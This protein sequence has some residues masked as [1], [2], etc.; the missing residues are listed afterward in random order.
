MS[1]V[2]EIFRLLTMGDVTPTPDT[3]VTRGTGV[4]VADG[5]VVVALDDSGTR[6]LLIPYRMRTKGATE[7]ALTFKSRNLGNPARPH[8]DLSCTRPELEGVFTAFCEHLL[9]TVEVGSDALVALRRA[10]DD[11]K[12]LLRA[13]SGM[14]DEVAIGLI[15][16]LTILERLAAVDP[17]AAWD[18]WTGHLKQVHDFTAVSSELEVKATTVLDGG[19]VLIHGLDQLDP[20]DRPLYLVVYRLAPD[21]GAPTLDE[22]MDTLVSMGIPRHDLLGVVTPLGH[23]YGSGQPADEH[24]Y[25]VRTRT[26]W[27]VGESFPG[28]RRSKLDAG[29]LA[30]V[31]RVRYTLSL[32][33]LPAPLA[34]AQ[35]EAVLGGLLAG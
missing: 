23:T 5:E 6:R 31:S 28:L 19:G 15:G 2:E 25:R 17:V 14:S 8:L 12:D 18:S 13:G 24:R 1:G 35:F 33:V 16:E 34:K 32:D 29:L 22:R 3:L 10:V 7:G 4:E 20:G 9:S 21:P 30:G 27:L 11:W 26:A